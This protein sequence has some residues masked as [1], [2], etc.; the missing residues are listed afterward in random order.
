M[1]FEGID[2]ASR[3]ALSAYSPEEVIGVAERLL[4]DSCDADIRLRAAAT[5]KH[6]VLAARRE[7][8][9]MR[10]VGLARE[11]LFDA[12]PQVARY[13]AIML[14]RLG[15]DEDM[16]RVG[17]RL[18][19]AR[20]PYLVHELF[21][22][23]VLRGAWGIVLPELQRPFPEGGDDA[24]REDWYLRVG[25]AM[26]FCPAAEYDGIEIAPEVL[27]RIVSLIEH[28]PRLSGEGVRSLVAME[29][30]SAVP[31]LHR[32]FSEADPLETQLAV[33]AGLI[34]LD[35]EW[36]GDRN[37]ALE[38]VRLAVADYQRGAR[39]WHRAVLPIKWLAFAAFGSEDIGLLLDIWRECAPLDAN[40][41][42]DILCE[43]AQDTVQTTYLLVDLLDTISDVEL[44]QMLVYSPE[45]R[46]LLGFYLPFYAY[47]KRTTRARLLDLQ[48]RERRVRDFIRKAE[49]LA[50]YESAN[51]QDAPR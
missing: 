24:E 10:L 38:I 30:T 3:E 12:D 23:L 11:I 6:Y 7:P 5:L 25:M 46:S 44:K 9:Q 49:F 31:G 8:L 39:P 50:T 34:I 36:R 19:S 17:E 18:E 32:I 37:V 28:Y 4:R 42:T 40:R 13:G 51:E 35:K 33:M 48:D 47:E 29:A 41:K 15:T 43:M 1:G 22:V 21:T 26:K 45:L 14:I 2:S 16:R 20:D 27:S